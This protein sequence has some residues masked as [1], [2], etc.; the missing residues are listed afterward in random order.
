[1]FKSSKSKKTIIKESVG[2]KLYEDDYRFVVEEMQTRNASRSEVLREL[3]ADG[4]RA[5]KVKN[6]GYDEVGELIK[7]Y[8][9][10]ATNNALRPVRKQLDEVLKN[11]DAS[12]REVGEKTDQI[13]SITEHT[14]ERTK[15]IGN[16]LERAHDRLLEMQSE[17]RDN[18]KSNLTAEVQKE[19]AAIR[20]LGE[21]AGRNLIGIRVVVWIYLFEILTPL[22]QTYAGV[23]RK[24]FNE[25]LHTHV[26]KL[27]SDQALKE[28]AYMQ[29][30]EVEAYIES[31]ANALYRNLRETTKVPLR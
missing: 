28:M 5:R 23:E 9:T 30:G 8:L 13:I 27:F 16:T 19:L 25:V 20:S 1:M 21:L 10:T 7:S 17:S 29:A 14:N 15:Q 24:A 4:I 11:V 3:I 22:V 12:N 18:A 6:N 31:E 26:Q 2:V